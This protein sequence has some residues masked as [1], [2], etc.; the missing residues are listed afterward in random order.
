MTHISIRLILV[1]VWG[2]KVAIKNSTYSSI[3]LAVTWRKLKP[4]ILSL[5]LA[6]PNDIPYPTVENLDYV[7]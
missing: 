6:L 7:F 3:R 2:W 5:I 1:V 4:Q